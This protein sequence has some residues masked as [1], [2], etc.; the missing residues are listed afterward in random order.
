MDHII[1]EESLKAKLMETLHAVH[2]V[3]CIIIIIC[4]SLDLYDISL[5]RKLKIYLVGVDKALKF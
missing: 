3:R 2:V 4:L 1:T 5:Y